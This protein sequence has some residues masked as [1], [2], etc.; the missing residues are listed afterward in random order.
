MPLTDIGSLEALLGE[1][2]GQGAAE[3]L[4]AKLLRWLCDGRG[5]SQGM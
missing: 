2:L 5:S 3:L 4:H 1:R